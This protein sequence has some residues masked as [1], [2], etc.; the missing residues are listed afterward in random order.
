MPRL[1]GQPSAVFFI[2]FLEVDQSDAAF[3]ASVVAFIAEAP[4]Q[5]NQKKTSTYVLS[6]FYGPAV[7]LCGRI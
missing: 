7:L 5:K 3:Y 2:D 4:P 6:L 1:I